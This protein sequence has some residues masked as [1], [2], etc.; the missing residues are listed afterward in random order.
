M[1]LSLIDINF[2]ESEIECEKLSY[3]SMCIVCV[4]AGGVGADPAWS[5]PDHLSAVS[6]S[7]RL[8]YLYLN[9]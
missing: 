7:F 1:L 2:V 9:I 5:M 8:P 3:F 4:W 6:A